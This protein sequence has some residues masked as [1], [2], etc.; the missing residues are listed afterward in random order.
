[1]IP[2]VYIVARL[3]RANW[4]F[5]CTILTFD[6]HQREYKGLAFADTL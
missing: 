4:S 1:M 6:R 5:Y 3:A 2:Y